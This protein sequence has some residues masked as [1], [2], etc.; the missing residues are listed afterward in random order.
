MLG[1]KVPIMYVECMP[2]P[3]QVYAILQCMEVCWGESTH[4]VCLVYTL[5]I[6]S[7]RN[8]SIYSMFYSLSCGRKTFFTITHSK[9][10]YVVQ[11]RPLNFG[12]VHTAA[13]ITWLCPLRH[14]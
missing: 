7:V 6:T 2:Y 14:S 3:S 13:A 5:P 10:Q 9:K 4:N 11:P 1:E 8:P 12:R